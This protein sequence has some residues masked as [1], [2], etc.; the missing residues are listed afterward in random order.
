MNYKRVIRV[1]SITVALEQQKEYQE[2][3]KSGD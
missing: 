1:N 3:I 2:L